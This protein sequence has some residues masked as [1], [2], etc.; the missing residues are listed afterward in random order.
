[1]NSPTNHETG[2]DS[3]EDGVRSLTDKWSGTIEGTNSGSVFAAFSQTNED[4]FGIVHLNDDEFGAAV[5]F[6]EGQ[7]KPDGVYLVLTPDMPSKIEGHGTV[8]LH[9]R[10]IGETK[11]VGD[12]QSSIGTGGWLDATRMDT[13]TAVLSPHKERLLQES[14]AR[15]ATARDE[16]PRN[17][18]NQVFI[19]Y[20]HDDKHWLE[21]LKVHL[22][23]LERD[24]DIGIWDDRKIS[25]GADWNEEI[26]KA[27]RSAKVALLII[28]ADFL[29]SDFIVNNELPPLL[30]AAENEGAV[31]LPLIVSPSRFTSTKTLSQ[32]QAIN[33]PFN[34]L[35]NLPKGEQEAVLVKVSEAIEIVLKST[36][37]Q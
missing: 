22:K 33:D 14:L 2:I 25:A 21:R 31:I 24:Y 18:R 12:W 36:P 28:S 27:I 16:S 1:M 34:P 37:T 29:A 9:A 35:I 19:S 11:L 32:F 26:E 8:I 4:V 13:E 23:P 15:Q 20:S 10:V 6:A 7:A 3:P 17:R 30:D 5:Y